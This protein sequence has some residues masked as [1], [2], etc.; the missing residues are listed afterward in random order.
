MDQEYQ[1]MAQQ[2][3]AEEKQKRMMANNTGM[4]PMTNAGMQT[5]LNGSRPQ[6]Q[7]PE[8]SHESER[9]RL[10]ADASARG[11]LTKQ[12]GGDQYY[13]DRSFSA[14][15]QMSPEQLAQMDGAN[16][17]NAI[18]IT[19]DDGNVEAKLLGLANDEGDFVIVLGAEDELGF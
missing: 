2:I 1:K 16:F 19:P 9:I 4:Q 8:M 3:L 12:Q 14:I 5:A 10:R 7:G 15:G 17:A 6:E 11:G 18:G 13:Q